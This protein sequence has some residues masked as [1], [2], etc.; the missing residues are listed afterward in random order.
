MPEND[1]ID[2]EIKPA[3]LLAEE[4]AMADRLAEVLKVPTATIT[5][6]TITVYRVTEFKEVD[7]WPGSVPFVRCDVCSEPLMPDDFI[8]KGWCPVHIKNLYFCKTHYDM[9]VA[10]LEERRVIMEEEARDKAK[11]VSEDIV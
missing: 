11:E 6:T 2:I 5:Q 3:I 1:K 7:D 10:K 9:G 8:G 4:K